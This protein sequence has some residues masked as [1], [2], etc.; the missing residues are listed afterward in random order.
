MTYRT[1][2]DLKNR[3]LS[4]RER[5]IVDSAHLEIKNVK[6]E[7]ALGDGVANDTAAIQRTL[8]SADVVLIP[9]GT[10]LVASAFDYAHEGGTAWTGAA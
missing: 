7:G 5:D 3:S 2:R 8:D 9:P 4:P 6:S 1:F 10:Y